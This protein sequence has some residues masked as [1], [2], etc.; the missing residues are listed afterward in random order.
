MNGLSSSWP[1]ANYIITTNIRKNG[2]RTHTMKIK[3]ASA[4]SLG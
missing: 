2:N 3:D 1:E 4:K